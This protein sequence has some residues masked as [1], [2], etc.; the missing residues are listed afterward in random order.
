[1]PTA[2]LTYVPI[3]VVDTSNIEEKDWLAYRRTR[4]GGSDVAAIMGVSPFTTARSLYY[5]K[6]GIH[7]MIQDD[8]NWVAKKVGH[9][10]EDLVA[11]IFTFK[12]GYKVFKVSKM[13]RHPCARKAA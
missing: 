7:P 4:I 9:L 3:E 11:E 13:F 1:M 2:T 5:D 8:T 10:L 12:T 6:C